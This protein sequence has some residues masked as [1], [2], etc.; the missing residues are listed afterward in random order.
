MSLIMGKL[1]I[2]REGP[3]EIKEANRRFKKRGWPANKIK[4]NLSKEKLIIKNNRKT[5]KKHFHANILYKKKYLNHS[6]TRYINK[7]GPYVNLNC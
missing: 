7:Y 2:T 3:V 5:I 4:I 6:H 1:L